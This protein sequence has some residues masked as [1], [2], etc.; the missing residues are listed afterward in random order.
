ML[1]PYPF[2]LSLK[3]A[4]GK[5]PWRAGG[6]SFEYQNISTIDNISMIASKISEGTKKAY[7]S[8]FEKKVDDTHSAVGITK[9]R[10]PYP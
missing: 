3:L 1:S 6:K 9:T 5:L 4:A 8:Y 7:N 2:D 10:T